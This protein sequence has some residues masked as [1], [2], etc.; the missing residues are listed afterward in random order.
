[1]YNVIVVKSLPNLSTITDPTT[2]D[3]DFIE[4]FNIQDSLSSLGVDLQKFQENHQN[5]IK[6]LVLHRSS[7]AG[8]N[9]PALL[10][11]HIDAIALLNDKPLLKK[12]E[13]YCS[14][15]GI[16]YFYN[17]KIYG[18]LN[19]H[20]RYKSE[21]EHSKLHYIYEKGNKCRIIAILDY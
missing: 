3:E 8:P 5:Q 12:F 19:I 1:M 20:E 10:T 14:I 21:P 6:V 2:A 4:N 17:I 15:E 13:K 9:G 11:S 16:N 7:S 18:K